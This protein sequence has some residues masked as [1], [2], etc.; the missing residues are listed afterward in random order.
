MSFASPSFKLPSGRPLRKRRQHFPLI[1]RQALPLRFHRAYGQRVV[2]PLGRHLPNHVGRRYALQVR[3]SVAS[4]AMRLECPDAGFGT[5]AEIRAGRRRSLLRLRG[6]LRL[7]RTGTCQPG[8][9][10]NDRELNI[11]RSFH[12]SRFPF[13]PPTRTALSSR[14]R[15]H[16]DR[17]EGSVVSFLSY[18]SLIPPHAEFKWYCNPDPTIS[19]RRIFP[20]WILKASVT[21]RLDGRL[22]FFIDTSCPFV[23]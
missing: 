10:Y 3:I 17:C 21:S 6:S 19:I 1:F 2:N 7:R 20:S 18:L 23:R 5:R 8:A 13:T 16:F 22:K 4:H 12:E 11:P 9:K 15:S 14:T